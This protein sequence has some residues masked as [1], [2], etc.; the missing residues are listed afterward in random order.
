MIPSIFAM[1]NGVLA[2][3]LM[4]GAGFIC[5]CLPVQ[6]IRDSRPD[7]LIGGVPFF[8]QEQYQC[9]PASL[10]MVMKY[11][12]VAV[13]PDEVAES[14]YSNSARGTL[15]LD[16]VIY[17]QQRGLSA[18]QFKGSMASVKQNIDL[19][20]PLI[21]LVDYGFSFYEAAH[22]MVIIGYNENGV[23]A[24]SGRLREHFIPEKEFLKSWEKTNYW[25]LLIK[26]MEP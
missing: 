24:N 2:L 14:I 5:S 7:A 19:G 13:T 4:A 11:R 6:E 1:L 9:G 16:M 15:N 21:V 17:A 12:D 3:F 20:N 25:T 10:A 8:P 23:I 18:L 26:R 22:F